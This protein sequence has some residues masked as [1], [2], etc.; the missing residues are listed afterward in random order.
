MIKFIREK[1][2]SNDKACDIHVK[3]LLSSKGH[4]ELLV[5]QEIVVA[6]HSHGLSHE[7]K[8]ALIEHARSHCP[9]AKLFD[10]KVVAFSY[11]I[12]EQDPHHVAHKKTPPANDIRNGHKIHHQH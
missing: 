6:G 11:L 7:Q 2:W 1:G 12:G 5:T 10:P 3:S 4:H 9:I 8:S